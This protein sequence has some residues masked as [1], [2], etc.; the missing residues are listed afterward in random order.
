[1]GNVLEEG[2]FNWKGLGK[3]EAVIG[4]SEILIESM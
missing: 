3:I 2:G 4:G 1:M